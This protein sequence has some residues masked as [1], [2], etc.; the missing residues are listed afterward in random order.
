MDDSAKVRYDMILGRDLRTSLVLDLI[1]SNRIIS[2]GKGP[3]EGCLASIVDV[4]KYDYAPLTHKNLNRKNPS[5][6]CTS[7]IVLGNKYNQPNPSNVYN[8]RC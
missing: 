5:F 8:S 6:I 1:F 3:Y 2:G 7:M 4:R